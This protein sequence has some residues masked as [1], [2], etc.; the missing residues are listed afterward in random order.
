[1]KYIPGEKAPKKCHCKMCDKYGNVI[2]DVEIGE[3][4]TLPPTPQEGGYY[5]ID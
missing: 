5:E 3:G 2:N 1:M 4:Q